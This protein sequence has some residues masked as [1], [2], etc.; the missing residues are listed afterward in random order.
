MVIGLEGLEN[1]NSSAVRCQMGSI[2]K[3]RV[4][5]KFESQLSIVNSLIPAFKYFLVA[6]YA[7]AVFTF[8]HAIKF[9]LAISVRST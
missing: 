3:F 6:L 7:I 1:L 9:N 5:P 8:C 2:C 4:K